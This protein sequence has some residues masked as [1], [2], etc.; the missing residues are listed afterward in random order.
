MPDTNIS[1]EHPTSIFSPEDEGSMF[2]QNISIYLKV[3]P[4]QKINIMDTTHGHHVVLLYSTKNSHNENCILLID[5]L[6][7]RISEC[8]T[9]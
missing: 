5:I 1:K 6:P 7:H 2:L 9:M 4:T 8:N 3:H